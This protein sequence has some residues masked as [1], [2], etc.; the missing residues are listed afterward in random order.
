MEI[1]EIAM[2]DWLGYRQ[3]LPL[4]ISWRLNRNMKNDVED[5]FVGIAETRKERYSLGVMSIGDI[6]TD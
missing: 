6:W 4:W 2:F 1:G 5:I 3:G